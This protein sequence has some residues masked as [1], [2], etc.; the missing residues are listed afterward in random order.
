MKRLL[1]SLSLAIVLLSLLI[2]PQGVQA[3][4][5]LPPVHSEQS[6]NN[7]F[8]P[9]CQVYS[10]D[11]VAAWDAVKFSTVLSPLSFDE[12]PG[13]SYEIAETL[14]I[15]E[16]PLEAYDFDMSLNR[17]WNIWL[18]IPA[19]SQRN[20]AWANEIM[21][22]CGLTI[23]SAGCLLTSA[24]MVFQFYGSSKN[25]KQVNECMGNKA[26]PWHFAEGADNCS[27]NKAGFLGIYNSTYDNFVWALS[28]GYPP[29]LEVGAHWVVIYGVS[30]SGTEDS[31]YYIVDPWDGNS[32][33]LTVYSGA[34]KGR[35]AIYARRTWTK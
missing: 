23:G 5:L 7:A 35:L 31:H 15:L 28:Q 9:A 25:P 16:A 27:E 12:A 32:K 22:T 4:S 33:S 6:T 18:P 8:C 1:M 34:P 2:G 30:G 14:P 17:N 10:L 21:Q 29:I 3:D 20:P 13:V 19:L 26:C 11:S 24:T